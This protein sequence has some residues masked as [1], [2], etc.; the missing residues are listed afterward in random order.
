MIHPHTRLFALRRECATPNSTSSQVKVYSTED[1]GKCCTS[2]YGRMHARFG[3]Q[4][5]N[6]CVNNGR[7]RLRGAGDTQPV[8]FRRILYFLYC[9]QHKQNTL[10]HVAL[11]SPTSLGLFC[12]GL[13]ESG[14]SLVGHVLD[15]TGSARD[16]CF[17]H[18]LRLAVARRACHTAQQSGQIARAVG[19]FVSREK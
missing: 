16:T 18:A 19:T 7:L 9:T 1:R 11:G 13:L 14:L 15:I 12:I 17:T 4:F 8:I 10:F 3:S 2:S 5:A 6:V